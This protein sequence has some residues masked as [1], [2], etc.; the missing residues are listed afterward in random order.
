[1]SKRRKRTLQIHPP[2]SNGRPASFELI[3]EESNR[4]VAKCDLPLANQRIE[5]ERD[6]ETRHQQYL[7]ERK[8]LIDGENVST[9]TLDKNILTL[10]GGALGLSLVFLEKIV[11]APKEW[12]LI[13]LS[14]AW[15]A[16]VLSLV[17]MLGSF[18]TSQ[19]AFRRQRKILEIEM[20]PED[21]VCEDGKKP[22]C[23]NFWSNRTTCLN[24]AS[25]ICFG[26]GVLLLCTFSILNMWKSNPKQQKG[27]DSIYEQ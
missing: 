9:D 2:S 19:H 15:L 25:I 5:A 16:L 24:W 10:S 18:L 20:F 4:T 12:T 23:K 27:L 6:Q 14:L 11:R 3:K 1:M 21:H 22:D 8:S 26:T 13:F 17:T 7:T